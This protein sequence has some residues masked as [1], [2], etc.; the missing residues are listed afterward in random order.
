MDKSPVRI[1]ILED[2][3]EDVE[4][5]VREL[6]KSELITFTH[7]SVASERP[8]LEAIETYKPELILADYSLPGYSGLTALSQAKQLSPEV[9]VIIVSGQIGEEVAIETMKA[10]ATDY[11][12]K[13]RL[14]RLGPVVLRALHEAREREHARY[15]FQ[16]AVEAAPSGILMADRADR[17]IL[18]N[19]QVEKMFGYLRDELIERSIEI[20]VPM[21]S[22]NK[23]YDYRKSF[24]ADQQTSSTGAHREEFFAL[25]KD[26]TQFPVEIGL[27]ALTT[28]ASLFLIA[29]IVDISERKEVERRISE[30]YSMISH[31]LRTP[32]VSIRGTLSL[33]DGG[34]LGQLPEKAQQLTRIALSELE[35]LNTLIN[36]ILDIKKIEAGKL[37][38]KFKQVV[39]SEII[40]T[41]FQSME[42]MA[43]QASI[44]LVS[45]VNTTDKIY[46]DRDHVVQVL[47]NLI[48][49][50]IKF[51]GNG[52]QVLVQAESRDTNTVHKIVRFSVIDKG[53]GIPEG[54][55]PKL[56]TQFQQ[57][58]QTDTMPRGGTGLGLAISKAIVE[59]HGGKIG[60]NSV[61]REGSTFWFELPCLKE[62]LAEVRS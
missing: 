16:T 32:L 19:T 18:V 7:H 10:G 13:Q 27:N 41:T 47:V 35:R 8:F 58:N 15:M 52:Q 33:L 26:G 11:V 55:I 57:V 62:E 1:L 53:R 45:Q 46:A 23:F 14:A 17:I 56:F 60:V 40:A 44:R 50:A 38:L 28:E 3:P 48:S 37:T 34:R 4:L 30:F 43:N 24:L 25:R 20:L 12:L 61:L 49:N 42:N 6:N 9:P 21:E 59:K 51:S 22:R 5:I 29:S 2:R 39:P 54:E 31:E 36:D